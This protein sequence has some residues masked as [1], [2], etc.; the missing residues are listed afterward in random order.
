MNLAE[1]SIQRRTITLVITTFLVF[2][3]V[4]AYQ[5]LGRL[6]DPEF[7]IK[8][9]QVFTQYPGATPRQVSEEVT[10]VIES[11][12]QEMGQLKKITSTSEAGLSTV[13]V[14]MKDKYDKHSLPQVWD[15]LRRKVNDCQGKLPPGVKPSLV[16]DD[17]GDVYGIYFCVY[18]D[19]Y[20]YAELK[21]YAKMLRREL[22]QVQDVGKVVLF[23]DQQEIVYLEISRAKLAQLGISTDMIAK[24]FNGQNLVGPAGQ[25]RVG[26][27]YVRIRPT[28]DI[29]SLEDIG[30]TL[31]LQPD[32]TATKLRLRDIARIDRSYADPPDSLIRF[33][34]HPAIGLGV[35]TV[36]GGNVVTM[37]DSL[38]ERIYELKAETPLGI[39]FGYI[40]VQSDSVKASISSFVINLIEAIVIVIGVLVV[41]MGLRSGMIIGAVLL[42]TVMATFIVMYTQGV[43]LERVSLG[44]LIIALGMLVDNAIVVVEGILIGARNGTSKKKAASDIV[45]QTTW[46]LFGATVIAVLAF[47]A[48][49]MSPDKT[50]EF[51]RSLF[52][53]ILY[54]LMLSWILAI[55]STPLLGVMFLK[56]DN[57]NAGNKDPYGGAFHVGY[58]RFLLACIKFRWVTM[59]VLL[60]ALVAAVVGFGNVKQSFFPVSTRPQFMVHYWLPQGTHI[61]RTERDMAEIEGF[62]REQEGVQNVASIVG[63]GGLRFLLTFTPENRNSAYGIL[64]VSVKDSKAIDGLMAATKAFVDKNLPDAQSFSR[65]FVLGPGDA[66]KIQV[67]F[68]G[69]NPKVLRQLAEAARTIFHE[70]PMATD[71]VDDWR[72]RVPVVR[73][74]IAEQQARNAGITRAQITQALQRAYGGV[75]IS[76]YR[77]GDELLPVVLRSPV[78]ERRDV[79]ALKY[80]QVWSPVAQRSVPLSELILRF[81]TTSE[82]PMIQRRNKLPTITVKCDPA[83][84]EAAPV[85]MKLM[86]RL[87]ERFH[88]LVKELNLTGY[89]MEWGGEYENSRDA[90][91]SLAGKLPITVFFMLLICIVL[92]NSLKKPLIIFLIVPMAIIGVTF[93][94]LVCNQPFGFMALLGLLSLVGMLI[95]NAI[96]LIDE[97]GLQLQAGKEPMD[98]IVSSGVSRLRPV[99][100]AALTTA[101]GIIPL[102]MDAFFASMAVTVMFGLTFA[103][104]LTLVVV[105]VLYTIVFKVPW[106]LSSSGKPSNDTIQKVSVP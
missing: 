34:G 98:A 66:Q 11:A 8:N 78:V 70:E 17:F 40:S 80:V 55:T 85:L 18:G 43:V 53:V 74:V 41:A 16:F 65:R 42:I 94:L 102:L 4:L 21:A 105:P 86:P 87:D 106:T 20:S 82:D 84:G 47:A 36:K 9:A 14:A 12:L 83:V 89:T 28:G 5:Q 100:M 58:K 51:C 77:E 19:G 81:E 104:V 35:S 93:G 22:L 13:M 61:T 3:G 88:Q 10:E 44:A 45:K 56:V 7:T 24:S 30:N 64:L 15:E 101:L 71:I 76:V 62:L 54:S 25:V 92:F 79:G 72:Q 1:L 49:G 26:S 99:S 60:V 52:Q 97:I 33:N 6:E 27:Q 69:E 57:S 103:T 68:R 38:T 23:G 91:A 67:R 46:P 96:V 31:I 2:G 29:T 75:T 39:E 59:L 95:K 73:P 90:Q 50:G 48:I 32:G 37:G 63:Q